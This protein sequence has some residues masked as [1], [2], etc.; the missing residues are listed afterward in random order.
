MEAVE[1]VI[2]KTENPDNRF[3]QIYDKLT[4]LEASRQKD[5]D[6]NK[7]QRINID[8]IVDETMFKLDCQI[9]DLEVYKEQY[10]SLVERVGE[11][12]DNI[13]EYMDT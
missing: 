12:K 10:Q 9:A 6:A 4:Y 1:Y 5:L 13:T 8:N 7:T 11:Q 2:Y 3:A